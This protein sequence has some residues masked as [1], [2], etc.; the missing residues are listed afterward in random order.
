MKAENLASWEN[1]GGA[2]APNVVRPTAKPQCAAQSG[3]YQNLFEDAPRGA[4]K[5]V[6]DTHTLTVMRL[7]LLLLI[8]AIGA[9]AIFWGLLAGSAPQ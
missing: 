1:E 9:M 7:A 8:P 2:P 5:G 3:M 6:S 4:D